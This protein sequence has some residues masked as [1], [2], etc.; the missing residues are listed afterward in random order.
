MI[1]CV[2]LKPSTSVI[3][4]RAG[5]YPEWHC[6]REKFSLWY[7][8]IQH[9][10]LLAYLNQLQSAFADFLY[11]PNTRQ[12]HITLFVCGFLTPHSAVFNDDFTIGQLQ[13]QLTE[14]SRMQPQT[15]QL[16]TGSIQSFSSALFVEIIDEQ[17]QL[18]KLRD[19]LAQHSSEIAPLAYCPHLTLGLYRDSFNSDL[20]FNQIEQIQ[21][22]TFDLSIDQLIFGTYQA[23]VLQ[24][25][26]S[27]FQHVQ[28]ETL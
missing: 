14:L 27:P 4:T 16:K 13:Q 17:G 11:A 15:I 22:K 9:P 5:D 21:Q 26:L 25:P 12:F 10:E 19:R 1:Y 24:G 20:I 28:L 3:A 7:L 18:L 2:F 8:E 6:G 23:Q